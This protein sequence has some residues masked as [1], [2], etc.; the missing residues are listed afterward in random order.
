MVG[1][2][3]SPQ[4]IGKELSRVRPS[5]GRRVQ[6]C[7]TAHQDLDHRGHRILRTLSACRFARAARDRE[8]ASRKGC[9]RLA[10]IRARVAGAERAGAAKRLGRLCVATGR[11]VQ[12]S[13]AQRRR[14]VSGVAREDRL[15][16]LECVRRS[17]LLH[18]GRAEQ[19]ERA[20]EIRT[21]LDGA[22][23]RDGGRFVVRRHERKP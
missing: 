6:C 16:G 3:R 8:V 20:L 15:E 14:S 13:D 2:H 23:G 19:Q 9:S 11:E 1:G 17:F 5:A 4:E 18:A 21:Q 22:P 10:D 7:G 12:E